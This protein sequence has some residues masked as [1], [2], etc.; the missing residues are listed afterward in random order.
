MQGCA[1]AEASQDRGRVEVR[2]MPG[3][4]RARTETASVQRPTRID[5][6]RSRGTPQQGRAGDKSAPRQGRA[7]VLI[8]RVRGTSRQRRIE[9][10]GTGAG[11]HAEA[12]ARRGRD[13]SEQERVETETH[14]EQECVETE[15]RQGRD[16][17]EQERAG[18]RA[19]A[20]LSPSPSHG[21]KFSLHSPSLH[22]CAKGTN[23]S[24]V[25]GKAGGLK[26][27]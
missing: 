20:R 21:A 18:D 27:P 13:P 2:G 9:T 3:Q 23:K 22:P 4:K 1:R 11:R 15:V 26:K 12:G 5:A 25:P 7:G 14:S 8:C 19:P 10:G 17:P 24:G 16:T 6:R